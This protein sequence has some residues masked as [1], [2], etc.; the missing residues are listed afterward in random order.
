MVGDHLEYELEDA[1][2]DLL[3]IRT[4]QSALK[5]AKR[6]YQSRI[7]T[8]QGGELTEKL[9]NEIRY[10]EEIITDLEEDEEDFKEL[11]DDTRAKIKK[12]EDQIA[13]RKLP[14]APTATLP[15][16]AVANN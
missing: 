5:R 7:F 9:R 1:E 2:T 16:P 12:L 14:T 6:D 10:Y 3:F 13:N 4:E 11:E 8:R 15:V